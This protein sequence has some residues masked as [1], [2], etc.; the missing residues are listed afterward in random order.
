MVAAEIKT[1]SAR[2]RRCQPQSLAKRTTPFSSSNRPKRYRSN[3]KVGVYTR[4][5]NSKYRCNKTHN[6]SSQPK[7][8]NCKSRNK[9]CPSALVT[10]RDSRGSARTQIFRTS[11]ALTSYLRS[12]SSRWGLKKI[13][14]QFKKTSTKAVNSPVLE[15]FQI[16]TPFCM[17]HHHITITPYLWPMTTTSPLCLRMA[18]MTV[19][20]PQKRK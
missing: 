13:A 19:D 6:K 8:R 18:L 5:T 10:Q 20:Q 16:T 12:Q 14:S 1:W 15:A 4:S 9:S 2:K 11:S 17:S 7:K 3:D